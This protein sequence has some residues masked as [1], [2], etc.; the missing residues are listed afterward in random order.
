MVEKVNGKAI[1]IACDCLCA[2][3]LST[4]VLKGVVNVADFFINLFSQSFKN[5]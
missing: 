1:D 4:D 5:D 2:R 3:E